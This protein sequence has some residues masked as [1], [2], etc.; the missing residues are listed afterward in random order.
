MSAS[1]F[2]GERERR[3][4]DPAVRLFHWALVALVIFSYVTGKAAGE[5]LVWHMRSGYAILALLLFRIAW[6]VVGSP[7]ARFASFVRSPS[8]ALRHIRG[9]FARRIERVAGHNPAGGW[10]VLLMLAILLAQAVSG[11]FVDDEIATQGPLT[12]KVS[13]AVVARMTWIHHW[14]EWLVVGVVAVHA[15]GIAF[16]QWVLRVNLVGPMVHGRL[17]EG[18]RPPPPHASGG[19]AAVLFAIACAVVYWLVTVYPR[20]NP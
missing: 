18:L 8:S 13:G 19:L 6:G 14:N 9:V 10:M 15:A 16:Y 12:G 1:A 2:G 20:A 4:W 7:N 17:G 3:A 5:W 11:L